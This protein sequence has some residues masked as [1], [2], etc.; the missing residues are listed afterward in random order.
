MP[1]IQNYKIVVQP[2]N[3]ILCNQ[4]IVFWLLKEMRKFSCL[5]KKRLK[6]CMSQFCEI[7]RCIRK[8]GN[9]LSL[10]VTSLVV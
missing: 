2:Q 1:I 5:K 4:K 10:V 3:G 7:H 9:N 6:L 8:R